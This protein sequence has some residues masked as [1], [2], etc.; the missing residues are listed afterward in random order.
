VNGRLQEAQAEAEAA[1]QLDPASAPSLAQLASVAYLGG[2]YQEA[3]TLGLQAAQLNPNMHGAHY[4]RFRALVLL[5]DAREAARA[6]ADAAAGW[7]A[8]TPE[9]RQRLSSTYT[10]LVVEGGASR[11][12]DFLLA[13]VSAGRP[14]LVNL[15]DRAVWQLWAGRPEAA[16]TELEAAVEARPF[17]AVYTAV[18]PAFVPLRNNP[19]FRKVV[20]ALGLRF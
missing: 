8:F 2:R 3:V 14:R 6:R 17:L 20:E 5:G 10:T 16:L 1:L 13:E 7:G 15:Y 12:A 19:R 11:L 4:W 18:D 9:A